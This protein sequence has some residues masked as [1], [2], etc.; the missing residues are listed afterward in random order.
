MLRF[1]IL[2]LIFFGLAKKFILILN[3]DKKPTDGDY[4]LHH[5]SGHR[6]QS[7]PWYAYTLTGL[8]LFVL[9][10]LLVEMINS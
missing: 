6:T 5:S 1:L 2:F 3:L 4:P 9:Y 8:G 10:L 7:S